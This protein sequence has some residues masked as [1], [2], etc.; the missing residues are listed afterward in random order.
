MNDQSNTPANRAP[1]PIMVFRDQLMKR[2][3]EFRH[4]LPSHIPAERFTRVVLTAVQRNPELLECDRGTLFNAC[5]RAANDGLLPDG[6]EGAIVVRKDRKKGKTANWTIMVGGIRKKVRNSGEI[7][8]WD[9]AV[10]CENDAFEFELGDEPFIR[11]RPALENRGKPIAAYSI[12]TLKT[13]EKSREVMGIG[14]IHGIRDRSDAWKAYKA[15]F[16]KSTPWSTDEGEMCRKTVARRH[17]KVLPM[18]TDLD[19]LIRRDDVLYNHGDASDKALGAGKTAALSDR[20]ANLAGEGS[21][22]PDDDGRNDD[23]PTIDGETGEIIDDRDDGD[24][25]GGADDRGREDEQ[26][27][28]GGSSPASDRGSVTVGPVTLPP[29]IPAPQPPRQAGRTPAAKP[30]KMG[31]RRL[32]TSAR[33]MP[34]TRRR[35]RR[36]SASARR[37]WA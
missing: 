31:R 10:V 32:R 33:R 34:T 11:H 1:A 24:A 18:S 7:A 8:T 5:L 36:R 21:M 17:S 25:N 9:T 27:S 15:G 20:L 6:A 2:E 12:C 19:D 14:E 23:A 28:D 22:L 13:G 29:T 35:S 16:I 4:S 26:H 30:P 3:G 37:K